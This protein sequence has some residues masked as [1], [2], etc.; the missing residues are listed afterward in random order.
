MFFIFYSKQDISLTIKY[1]FNQN[2]ESTA[3]KKRKINENYRKS[4][5]EYS[6]VKLPSYP[7]LNYLK[8][9]CPAFLDECRQI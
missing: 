2:T 6:Q 4:I 8:N 9:H 3:T 7:F 1:V 5:L